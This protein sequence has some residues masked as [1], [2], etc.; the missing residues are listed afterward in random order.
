MKARLANSVLKHTEEECA[1][2]GLTEL[3]RALILPWEHLTEGHKN[4][5]TPPHACIADIL[6]PEAI[7][8]FAKPF[9]VSEEVAEVISAMAG[10]DGEHID[11]AAERAAL[12]TDFGYLEF[13][14][15]GID[16]TC[17]ALW[18]R[19]DGEKF[20]VLFYLMCDEPGPGA[21][22]SEIIE[23]DIASG[24]IPAEK[25]SAARKMSRLYDERGIVSCHSKYFGTLKWDGKIQLS[26]LCVDERVAY[27]GACQFVWFFTLFCAFMMTPR[28]CET[29]IAGPSRLARSIAAKRQL[30]ILS[31]NEV[32]FAPDR[33]SRS[34][35]VREAERP[36]VRLHDVIAHWRRIVRE[37]KEGLVFVRAHT[38]GNAR[39]GV[40][41]K[42]R[43]LAA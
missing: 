31:F 7:N 24:V 18:R 23:K 5:V 32:S 10:A 17:A 21:S 34:K 22:V 40:V 1:Q 25:V 16:G 26:D 42:Q 9:I 12:P 36:G 28:A 11:I 38:R 39:K 20:A 3:R 30:P 2:S 8:D 27:R 33:P 15:A 4:H 14:R 43:K 6:A 19:I 35:K 41:L 29:K 37:G 13:R